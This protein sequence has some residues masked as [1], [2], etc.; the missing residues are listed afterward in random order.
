MAKTAA[1]KPKSEPTADDGGQGKSKRKLIIIALAVLLLIGA[2]VGGFLF[3]KKSQS[4]DEGGDEAE[5]HEEVPK[6]KAKKKAAPAVPPTYVAIDP[7]SLNLVPDDSGER[8]IHLGLSL[9]T[10]D[11]ETIT[12]VKQYMPELRNRVIM[13]LSNK[14]PSDLLSTEGKQKLAEEI[15]E[16]CNKPFSEGLSE[17][18][19]TEILFTAFVIQ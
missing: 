6:K 19:V 10:T 3:W 5:V 18:D 8:Y 16:A 11:P 9:K 17:Q 1:A 7:V 12:A 2:G 14:K 4:H 15:R 13:V